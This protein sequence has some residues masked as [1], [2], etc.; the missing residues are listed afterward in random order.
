MTETTHD[1]IPDPTR[2]SKSSNVF[3]LMVASTDVKL[4]PFAATTMTPP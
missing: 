4:M 3:G 2:A 1:D